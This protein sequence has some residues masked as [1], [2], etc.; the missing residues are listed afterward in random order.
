MLEMSQISKSLRHVFFAQRATSK[1]VRVTFAEVY[2][3][4]ILNTSFIL[5][6]NQKLAIDSYEHL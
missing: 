3:V 4:F 5:P 1:V 2:V 6:H